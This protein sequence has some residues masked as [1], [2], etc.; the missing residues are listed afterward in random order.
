MNSQS[1]ATPKCPVC[2]AT[3]TL[4]PQIGR[5]V[6]PNECNLNIMRGKV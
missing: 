4:V 3:K 1:G 6:C 2:G 5:Y